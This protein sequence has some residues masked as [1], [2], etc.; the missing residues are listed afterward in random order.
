MAY[1]LC[2]DGKQQLQHAEDHQG[3][4]SGDQKDEAGPPVPL[5]QGLVLMLVLPPHIEPGRA[6]Q[7]DDRRKQQRI[8]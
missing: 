1:F 7:T 4:G 3:R 6:Q 5:G 8:P 2:R